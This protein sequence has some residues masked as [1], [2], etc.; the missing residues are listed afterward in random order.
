MHT[1]A[2]QS[3]FDRVLLLLFLL[4]ERR[5]ASLHHARKQESALKLEVLIERT[6]S[7]AAEFV[8]SSG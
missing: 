1:A 8:T 6:S 3:S 4:H 7:A 5:P 2:P